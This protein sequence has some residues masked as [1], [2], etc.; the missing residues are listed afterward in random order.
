[1]SDGSLL[2]DGVPTATPRGLLYSLLNAITYSGLTAAS[3][4]SHTVTSRI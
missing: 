4:L 1:M 2:H 3:P